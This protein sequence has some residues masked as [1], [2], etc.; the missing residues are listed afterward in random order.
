MFFLDS[1]L[2]FML[3]LNTKIFDR[4]FMKNVLCLSLLL[5]FCITKL[6]FASENLEESILE[7]KITL[8]EEE[9]TTLKN[10]DLGTTRYVIGG[11]VGTYPGLG[12]GHAIQ[13]RWMSKGWIFTAGELVSATVAMSGLTKCLVEAFGQQSCNSSTATVG[14]LG[15]VIFRVWEIVDVWK[16]GYDQMDNYKFLKQKVD[17]TQNSNSPKAS[18]FI[19]PI[20]SPK[21]AGLGLSYTF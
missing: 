8:T 3:K 20:L 2:Q 11:I 9:R 12:I 6:S 19:L 13:G 16:G 4:I 1:S 7:K 21:S 15:L 17:N 5:T 18:L 14:I 10:G